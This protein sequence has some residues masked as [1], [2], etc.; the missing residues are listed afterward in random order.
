MIR[1]TIWLAFIVTQIS[2]GVLTYVGIT[3]LGTSVEAN[4]LLAWYIAAIGITAAIVGA[5]L[6]ALACG[7]LLYVLARHRL[8]AVLTAV[9]VVAAVWPWAILLWQSPY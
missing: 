6:F 5:K 7:I 4:P 2:D 9:Y 3:T 8:I 1:K